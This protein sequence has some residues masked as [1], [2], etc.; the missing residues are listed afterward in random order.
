MAGLLAAGTSLPQGATVRGTVSIRERGGAAG[1]PSRAVVWIEAA[2]TTPMASREAVILMSDKTFDP[3]VVTVPAGS[4]VAFPNADPI[5]HNVFSVSRGNSFDLGLYG[6]GEGRVVALNDPG[7]VRVYCNVHPQMEAFVVVTPGPWAA[8][9]AADG[10]YVL[11]DV[12]QGRIEVRVW[13]ERGG[14]DVRTV[15]V[16]PGAEATA[17]FTLDAAGWRRRPHLN[18]NGQ[19]YMGKDRY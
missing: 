7:V 11:D 3:P 5:L 15:E 2:P 19:P 8:R 14:S 10:S 1:D 16:A 4:R 18:K 13:D 6:R 12:P 17:D 9:P